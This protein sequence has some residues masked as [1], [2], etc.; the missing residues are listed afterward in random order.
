MSNSEAGG[1]VMREHQADANAFCEHD[2]RLV[3]HL[4]YK[5]P[6]ADEPAPQGRSNDASRIVRERSVV[7]DQRLGPIH[8]RK[9]ALGGMRSLLPL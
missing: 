9:Q 1:R 8:R 7:K 5:C 6:A 4:A 3:F 2:R